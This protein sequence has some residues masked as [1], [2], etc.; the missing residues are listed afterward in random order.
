MVRA[1]LNKRAG[2][3]AGMFDEV[4]GGY[5][6]TNSVLS[7]GLDGLWRAATVRAAA[8]LGGERVL[9]LAAGTGASSAALSRGGATVVAADFSPGM[10]EVG[11]RRHPDIEFVE[12]DAAALPFDDA[13]FDVV[14]ISFGLRNVE[15]PRAALAEMSRVLKPGGRVV[16][17]EFSTPRLPIFRTAYDAYLRVVMPAVVRLASS[18]SAAYGYL[19]ES[20]RDWP[21]QETLSR[22]LRGAGFSRVAHRDLTLGVVALHRGRKPAAVRRHRRASA[23]TTAGSAGDTATGST[24][25]TPMVEPTTTPV[26]PPQPAPAD[27]DAPAAP[28]GEVVTGSEAA[29][30]VLP[31]IT[32]AEPAASAS[33][34]DDRAGGGAADAHHDRPADPGSDA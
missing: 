14:T 17:C 19:A 6:R 27:P 11:R 25:V 2:E 28:D 16:V 7:F 32:P 10:I 9:D 30:I 1:D 31:T 5:D 15:D 4:A 8:P 13:E 29:P 34:D 18:N 26:A 22:W 33:S 3:V 23:D 20:I 12:A 21:D 24:P